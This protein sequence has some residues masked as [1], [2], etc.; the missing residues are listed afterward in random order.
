[1]RLLDSLKAQQLQWA[2]GQGF[3][4]DAKGYVDDI[5]L[6]L[7]QPMSQDTV[8]DFTRGSGGELRARRRGSR[9]KMHALHSSSVLACNVFDYWRTRGVGPLGEAFGIVEP[10]GHL[11]FE[12]Q[13]P[14]GLLGEPPNLDV[15]LWL[16]LGDVWGIESKFT[17][18]F[19][20]PKRGPMFKDKYFT[21]GQPIWQNY[22]LPRAGALAGAL[23]N[24]ATAYWNLDAAQ[25]LK[26]ALGLQMQHRGRFTLCYL[27]VDADA[28][29]AARHRS[30][31]RGFAAAVA[32]DF[33][34]L[35]LSYS[36][37]VSKL[38]SVVDRQHDPYFA[39][40]RTR[41]GLGAT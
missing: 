39:Y 6:N 40:L 10:V 3:L 25:L 18:P 2:Q 1:M 11:S 28:P 14:T 13:F 7:L 29:E 9:P 34:F 22:G 23:Q 41:Y 21:S 8:A 20:P 37:F 31:I 27:Y 30:E 24:G 12:A 32:G 35:P 33:P 15:A 17:E 38:R 26:H 16:E 4:P 5:A 36:S 19:G